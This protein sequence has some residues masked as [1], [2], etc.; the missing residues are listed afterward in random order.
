MKIVFGE[1]YRYFMP[2][3][4]GEYFVDSFDDGAIGS[5]ATNQIDRFL[6]NTFLERSD[7]PSNAFTECVK[8]GFNRDTLL[9]EVNEVAFGKDAASGGYPGWFARTLERQTGKVIQAD[10]K[11]ICLLLKESSRASSAEGI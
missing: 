7:H 2:I 11:S 8:H 1:D 6:K 9:L 5:N 10:A 3:P 4:G